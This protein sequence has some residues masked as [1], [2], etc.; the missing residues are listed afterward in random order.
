VNTDE[1]D[2]LGPEPPP[3]T[4]TEAVI[5]DCE[6]MAA[7]GES[8]SGAAER[9]GYRHRDVLERV[10]YRAERYDLVSRLRAAET[11]DLVA[12][13]HAERRRRHRLAA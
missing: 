11:D 5:E 2:D 7:T 8:L 12:E 1:D 9:L 6:F 4:R 13:H 3:Q 10:L